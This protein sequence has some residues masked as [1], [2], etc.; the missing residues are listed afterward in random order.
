MITIYIA[1]D[2]FLI[3]EGLK[4]LFEKESDIRLA[5]EGTNADEVINFAGSHHVD[6][7]I[8]DINLPGKN[9]F[10]VLEYIKRVKPEIKVLVLSMESEESYGVRAIKAGASGYLNKEKSSGE[11]LHAIRTIADGRR[12]V[13]PELADKLAEEMDMSSAR[14]GKVELSTREF[15]VLIMYAKGASQSDIAAALSVSAGTVSTYR[16]RIM[17]KLG[18][19]TNADLIMYAVKNKLL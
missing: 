15:E 14:Q 11:L 6:I 19:K 12:Y 8:L 3:R 4:K 5:G 9:G 10:E 2:H 18:A 7:I 13:G 16:S 17:K 1:D